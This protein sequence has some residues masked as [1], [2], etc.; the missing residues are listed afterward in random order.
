MLLIEQ[1]TTFVKERELDYG[2]RTRSGGSHVDA[3]EAAEAMDDGPD[4]EA[5]EERKEDDVAEAASV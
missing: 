4:D 2:S 3:E 1:Y 5:D